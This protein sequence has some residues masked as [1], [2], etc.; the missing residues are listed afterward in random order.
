MEIKYQLCLI[1]DLPAPTKN[2]WFALTKDF[3]SVE[4]A[5]ACVKTLSN[6]NR[7]YQIIKIEV[8]K[9]TPTCPC[10]QMLDTDCAGECGF[11][12]HL[13]RQRNRD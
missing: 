4:E 9:Q 12:D 10:M 5:E 8:V 7:P 13:E 3:E 1:K 2:P 11:N 6:P